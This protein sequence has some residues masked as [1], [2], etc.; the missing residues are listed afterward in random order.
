MKQLFLLCLFMSLCVTSAFAQHEKDMKIH[1]TGIR[2][3]NKEDV[4]STYK[5]QKHDKSE[6]Y[7]SGITFE[8]F[9]DNCIALALLRDEYG[10]RF[11][12][13]EVPLYCPL[14]CQG[15]RCKIF[16]LK[17]RTVSKFGEIFKSGLPD[18]IECVYEKG[19]LKS[20]I[21]KDYKS[22]II[23]KYDIS[24]KIS[25]ISSYDAKSGSLDKSR[26]FKYSES[27]SVWYSGNCRYFTGYGCW[28]RMI[29]N[30]T[31]YCREY[32]GDGFCR[33]IKITYE[34]Y[35]ITINSYREYIEELISK[36]QKKY[37]KNNIKHIKTTY[38]NG[39]KFYTEGAG[40]KEYL[41]S[42]SGALKSN[43]NNIIEFELSE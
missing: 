32:Q 4:T 36:Q 25:N 28:F 14:V 31:F 2:N 43:D 40:S 7:P 6:S 22:V 26:D 19:L 20:V 34:S 24:N 10:V 30:N 27:G 13:E 17:Y 5:Q 23:I 29:D 33:K 8:T 39:K 42:N 38:E 12:P 11:I 41:F 15:N 16:V 18:T 37:I 35:K 9:R 1:S 21:N 3:L